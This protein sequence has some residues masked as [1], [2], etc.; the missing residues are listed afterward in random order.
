MKHT[1]VKPDGSLGQ[2]RE[3]DGAA[4]TLAPNKGRWLPDNPPAF[5]SATHVRT[6]T[7]PVPADASE[8]PYLVTPRN[9]AEMAAEQ[10]AAAR[11]SATVRIAQIRAEMA[12]QLADLALGNPSEQGAARAAL[13]LLRAELVLNKSRL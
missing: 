8:V 6:V 10:A 12:D 5:N 4:P 11:S 2:S 3:F 13:G 7:L 9:P 1:L